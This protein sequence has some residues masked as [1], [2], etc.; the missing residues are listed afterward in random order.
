MDQVVLP[1]PASCSTLFRCPRYGCK[2]HR[3][4]SR[5]PGYGRGMDGNI[6][7]PSSI[8]TTALR[9]ACRADGGESRGL[10]RTA[11]GMAQICEELS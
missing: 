11:E 4:P 6:P 10:T 9:T 8:A 7:D 2:Q 3:L 5:G 1:L